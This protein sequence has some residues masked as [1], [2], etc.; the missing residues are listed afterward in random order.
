MN[1]LHNCSSVLSIQ[2]VPT[3][4]SKLRLKWYCNNMLSKSF[5]IRDG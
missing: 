5:P 2:L 4:I 1:D 3:Y